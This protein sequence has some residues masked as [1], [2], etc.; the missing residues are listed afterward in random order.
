VL[1]P[2]SNKE[3]D[4]RN[5][6]LRHPLFLTLPSVA[7]PVYIL[8][9][10]LGPYKFEAHQTLG[11][12]LESTV[13]TEFIVGTQLPVLARVIARKVV[14]SVTLWRRKLSSQIHLYNTLQLS[15]QKQRKWYLQCGL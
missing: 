10:I 12:D 3:D 4:N 14:A 5:L 7:L 9:L 1:P 6:I 13:S 11:L 8:S 15:A 2:L